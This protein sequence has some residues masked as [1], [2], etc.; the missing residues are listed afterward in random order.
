MADFER[1]TPA[2]RRNAR[3]A[4]IVPGWLWAGTRYPIHFAA[5]HPGRS[6]ALAYAAAGE[7]GLP[8]D[9][10]AHGIPLK[11]KP[12]NDYFVKG[13]PSYTT[14][15]PGKWF[16]GGPNSL[17]R[18]QSLSPYS[19]P[20]ETL[21]A[22]GGALAGLALNRNIGDATRTLG[23]FANPLPV[24]A[25]NTANR[26]YQTTSGETK[27][28]TY[29]DAARRNLF[30]RLFPTPALAQHLVDPSSDKSTMYTDKSRL[31]ILGRD[32][33]V[34]PVEVDKDA[35]LRAKFNQQGLTNTAQRVDQKTN[36]L[37]RMDELG[38]KPTP[39]FLQIYSQKIE[40]IRRAETFRQTHTGLDFQQRATKSDLDYYLKLG[41]ISE[42]TRAAIMGDVHQVVTTRSETAAKSQLKKWRTAMDKHYLDP[43]GV[44]SQTKDWLTSH[45]NDPVPAK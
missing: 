41:L 37:K 1:M 7:P 13:L 35:A 5:T 20:G 22:V 38:V 30:E 2:Q 27:K 26:V 42:K 3:R 8:S 11:N 21:G 14:A 45:Q 16:G 36:D 12:L 43:Q 28:T 9:A 6:A 18:V 34:T 31:G 40:R 15:L 25:W 4:F 24:S 17:E 32:V 10:R 19:T 44:Y 39:Q 29:W 33:G 23:S